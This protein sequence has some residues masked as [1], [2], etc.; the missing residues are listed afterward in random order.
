[1]PHFLNAIDVFCCT[2]LQ[3]P[4][5]SVPRDTEFASSRTFVAIV[6]FQRFKHGVALMIGHTRHMEIGRAHV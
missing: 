2:S 3:Y 5:Y 4:S 1:M 6:L